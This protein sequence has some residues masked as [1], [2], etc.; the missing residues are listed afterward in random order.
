MVWLRTTKWT[1][2]WCVTVFLVF[3]VEVRETSAA[4]VRRTLRSWLWTREEVAFLMSRSL[5][6]LTAPPPVE[7]SWWTLGKSATVAPRR[8]ADLQFGFGHL[9]W[10]SGCG[11]LWWSEDCHGVVWLCL[12]VWSAPGDLPHEAMASGK[13]CDTILFK[14]YPSVF[15]FYCSY[16]IVTGIT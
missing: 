4:A 5:T 11:L 6:K 14:C 15:C 10:R 16:W 7:T 3:I 12:W 8:S 1:L 9:W 2:Q 13:H